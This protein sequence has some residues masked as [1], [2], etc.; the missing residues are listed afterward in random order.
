MSCA[1]R[2]LCGFI[3][4]ATITEK[5]CSLCVRNAR[6]NLDKK[7]KQTEPKE[8]IVEEI[9]EVIE[10]CINPTIQRG[11]EKEWKIAMRSYL[12]NI[13]EPLI[14]TDTTNKEECNH[15]WEEGTTTCKMCGESRVS[16]TNPANKENEE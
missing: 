13:L 4:K 6:T 8:H 9:I 15:L 2:Q 7:M 14:E 12:G 5:K 3:E 1:K 16:I 11:Y 10:S